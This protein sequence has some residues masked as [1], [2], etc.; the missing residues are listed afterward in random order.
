MHHERKEQ[1]QQQLTPKSWKGTKKMEA[2]TLELWTLINEYMEMSSKAF[3]VWTR[4]TR[5]SHYIWDKEGAS[6]RY[7]RARRLADRKYKESCLWNEAA[8]MA[9][10]HL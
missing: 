7:S 10:A 9:I 8:R 1:P 3:A 4:A 2:K 6:D 5:V